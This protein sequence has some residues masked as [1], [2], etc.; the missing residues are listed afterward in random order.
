MCFVTSSF[1]E[2]IEQCSRIKSVSLPIGLSANLVSCMCVYVCSCM[3]LKCIF[4]K[5]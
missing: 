1:T 4:F 2:N 3:L 5:F